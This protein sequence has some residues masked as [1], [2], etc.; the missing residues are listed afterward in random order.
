MKKKLISAFLGV[1]VAMIGA[2][3]PPSQAATISI[4]ASDGR[5]GDQIAARA[6]AYIGTLGW[7]IQ[8]SPAGITNLVIPDDVDLNN[9]FLMVSADGYYDRFAWDFG[10]GTGLTV[11]AQ[12][13]VFGR[14]ADGELAI[15]VV[16]HLYR[17][18]AELSLTDLRLDGQ[19][20]GQRLELPA[21]G[22]YLT[23][24]ALVRNPRARINRLD[25]RTVLHSPSLGEADDHH[26]LAKTTNTAR[27][28]LAPRE[29]RRVTFRQRLPAALHPGWFAIAVEAEKGWTTAGREFISIHKLN[30]P[31]L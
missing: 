7:R 5:S 6:V 23:F 31:R 14:T 20:V 25:L 19:P 8:V 26:W 29:V 18:P 28:H 4:V 12:P 13:L 1:V 2:I 21:E 10:P 15:N 3:A 9:V 17:K 27:L 16:A 30:N 22:G 11:E 24:R